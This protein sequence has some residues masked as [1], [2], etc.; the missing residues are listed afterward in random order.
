M[1]FFHLISPCANIFFVFRRP[2][3][4]ISFLMVRPLIIISRGRVGYEMASDEMEM[5]QMERL[6][7][8]YDA[9]RTEVAIM[10]GSI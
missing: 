2:L 1:N 5:P 4:P 10:R 6:L 8:G 3:S 7:E 9:R